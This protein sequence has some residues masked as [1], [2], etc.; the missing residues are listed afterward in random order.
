MHIY[1]VNMYMHVY[2]YIDMYMYD[3][4]CMSIYIY[5]YVVNMI[6]LNQRFFSSH[7]DIDA[8]LIRMIY[9]KKILIFA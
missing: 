1:I 6:Y 9:A 3:Y 8:T 2:I 4:V 7:N 5:T